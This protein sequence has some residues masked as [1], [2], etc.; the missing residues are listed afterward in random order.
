MT[1]ESPK[2]NIV[3]IIIAIIGVVG[4]I[5]A[6][7]I[8][9]ISNYNIERLRQQSELTKIAIIS[10]ST[11]SSATQSA[12]ASTIALEYT[13]LGTVLDVG[14]TWRQGDAELTLTDVVLHPDR[15]DFYGQLYTAWKFTNISPN[16]IVLKFGRSN[17]TAQTNLGSQLKILGFYGGAF[18]CDNASIVVKSGDSLDFSNMCGLGSS[19][20]MLSIVVNLG[21]KQITE[22]VVSVD[23]ISSIAGAKWRI[24][25]FH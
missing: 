15:E 5:T 18:W 16:D 2:S 12:M 24:P 17:F 20:Y 11:Q 4:T 10:A 7:V 3:L 13:N 9:G 6:S 8:G 14:Q 23:G 1:Q 19:G 25:I 21:N 22:V